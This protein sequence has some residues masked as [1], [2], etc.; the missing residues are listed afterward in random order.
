MLSTLKF[1]GHRKVNF[2][3][4]GLMLNRVVRVNDRVRHQGSFAY[5]QL[6]CTRKY[7]IR[8]WYG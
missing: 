1:D 5:L 7:D 3:V 2:R 4:R 8:E 6:M